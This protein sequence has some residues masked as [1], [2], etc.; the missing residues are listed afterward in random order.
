VTGVVEEESAFFDGFT[1][2]TDALGLLEY[3]VLI[4]EMVGCA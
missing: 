3:E 1:Q 4:I 2:A